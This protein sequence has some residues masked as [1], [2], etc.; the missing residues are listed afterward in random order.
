M[1]LVFN[2]QLRFLTVAVFVAAELGI[3]IASTSVSDMNIPVGRI[4]LNRAYVGRKVNL[5]LSGSFGNRYIFTEIE[6]CTE[7]IT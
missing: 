3:A 5:F 1:R 6:R 2:Y 4:S 7:S